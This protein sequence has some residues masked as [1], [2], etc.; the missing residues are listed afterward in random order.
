MPPSP[1]IPVH[2]SS[3]SCSYIWCWTTSKVNCQGRGTL[4]LNSSHFQKGKWFPE[5]TA[6]YPDWWAWDGKMGGLLLGPFLF[7]PFLGTR[8]SYTSFLALLLEKFSGDNFNTNSCGC[9]LCLQL[10]DFVLFW[11][12]LLGSPLL[13]HTKCIFSSPAIL[14]VGGIIL[15][16]IFLLLVSFIVGSEYGY[17]HLKINILP[18]RWD[19]KHKLEW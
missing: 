1:K 9:P 14:S 3:L 17:G 8:L 2:A 18:L 10:G 16:F 4:F 12:F 13:P 15:I 19:Y 11:G 7:N 5:H 6:S